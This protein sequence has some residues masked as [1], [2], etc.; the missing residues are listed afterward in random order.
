M[1]KLHERRARRRI[2]ASTEPPEE[3]GY[4]EWADRYLVLD[5][6]TKYSSAIAPYQ[7]G[8]MQAISDPLVEEVSIMSSVQVMKTLIILGAIGYFAERSPSGIMWA[9]PT[10][11]LANNISKARLEL[12]FDNTPRL[13]NLL[14]DKR[15]RDAKNSMRYKQIP[16]GYIIL[17]GANSPNSFSSWP[18]TYL[19][20]DEIDRWGALIKD[21]GDIL[22]LATKRTTAKSM[23]KHVFVSSPTEKGSSRIHP[24]YMASSQKQY[25][26]PCP[27]CNGRQLLKFRNLK[28]DYDHEAIEMLTEINRDYGDEDAEEFEWQRKAIAEHVN[29]WFVCEHCG[30]VIEHRHKQPMVAAGEWRA[31]YP[32]IVKRQG[33]HIWQ[34]YSPFVTWAETSV[35][36]LHS[37]GFPD[38]MRV[39]ANT[40]LGELFEDK[41]GRIDEMPLMAR[42]E[43]YGSRLPLAVDV[44][45]IGI[46]VQGDRFEAEVIGWA[47]DGENWSL[48]Y[49]VLY[50][51][52]GQF[53][54]RNSG[55][56]EVYKQLYPLFERQY[57]RE[58]GAILPIDAIAIDCGYHTDQVY[59]FIQVAQRMYRV[60]AVMGSGNSLKGPLVKKARAG[61]R[62]LALWLIDTDTAK[63]I[64]LARL[65]IEPGHPGSAHWP[66]IDT[67]PGEIGKYGREYFMGLTA[68]EVKFRAGVRKWEKI[69]ER[70]EPVDTRV[71][72]FA[73][74]RL[75]SP[76][77]G[78][79]KRRNTDKEK[80][81][82]KD[83]KDDVV[84]SEAKKSSGRVGVRKVK[85]LKFKN[86]R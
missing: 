71:Y 66:L 81:D 65:E 22:Y 35:E 6:G 20:G 84:D 72:A 38:R 47:A 39:F 76:Q 17:S 37:K 26:V 34:A 5:D 45:T 52:T 78:Q 16:G 54:K 59:D 69:R 63:N 50:G 14:T 49:V 23:R 73:A 30:S 1:E 9:L 58:D 11:E 57:V 56:D 51:D 44:I 15:T 48:D 36:F 60:F 31:K 74:M 7:I 42:R 27:H 68:E 33:F 64:V 25:F 12:M 67:I 80:P 4:P 53:D 55:K 41:T 21:E 13:R 2:W 62:R 29:A 28:F 32:N 24:L 61:N 43:V 46:D 79:I 8:P 77:W 40:V 3:I 86:H 85:K 82:T 83:Y 18:I 10:I 70:N 75:L 19:F